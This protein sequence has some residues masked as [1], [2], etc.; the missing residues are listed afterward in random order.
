[1]KI[2][3]TTL[4]LSLA[5]CAIPLNT[6][7]KLD[8]IGEKINEGAGAINGA[9]ALLKLTTEQLRGADTNKDGKLSW[10]ELAALLAGLGGLAGAGLST[11]KAGI[12]QTQVDQLYDATHRPNLPT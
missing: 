8:K 1:M 10:T 3:A 9:L 11:R 6:E 7:G 4:L 5:S 12:A 2:I